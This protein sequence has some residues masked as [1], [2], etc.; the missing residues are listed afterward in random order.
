MKRS[1]LAILSIFSVAVIS[2]PHPATG[3]GAE[4]RGEL[5][6]KEL[7]EAGFLH[8]IAPQEPLPSDSS[9]TETSRPDEAALPNE[10]SSFGG[11]C[12][13][14]CYSAAQSAAICG[15]GLVA[16]VT[17]SGPLNACYLNNLVCK[18]FCSGPVVSCIG[19]TLC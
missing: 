2:M 17:I 3:E 10:A 5:S 4:D 11:G 18:P 9:S 16:E 14:A 19:F 13:K 8:A 7:V 15:S 1:M 12:Y 6:T